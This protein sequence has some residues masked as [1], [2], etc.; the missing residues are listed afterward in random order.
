MKLNERIL[1]QAIEVSFRT[2]AKTQRAHLTMKIR[3]CTRLSWF[4]IYSYLPKCLYYLRLKRWVRPL[5]SLQAK[6]SGKSFSTCHNQDDIGNMKHDILFYHAMTGWG[7]RSAVFCKGKKLTFNIL[8]YNEVLKK[9]HNYIH[10]NC[11]CCWHSTLY[12]RHKNF[13]T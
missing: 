3:C 8:K 13:I 1:I 11:C 2:N 4:F 9:E 10:R 12:F 5:F 6:L 7:T